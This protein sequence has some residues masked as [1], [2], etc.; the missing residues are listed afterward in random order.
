[1]YFNLTLFIKPNT[2]ILIFLTIFANEKKIRE[3]I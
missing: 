3:L 2:L 1:M